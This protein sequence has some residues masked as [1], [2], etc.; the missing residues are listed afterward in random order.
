MRSRPFARAIAMYALV[1]AAMAFPIGG[2]RESAMRNI[3]EY[4]S[5]GKGRGTY[6]ASRNT[7][8]MVQRAAKKRRNKA[9]HK[10]ACRK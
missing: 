7:A 8:A 2:G 9:R 4:K 3:G 6:Q 5:R 10:A 1:Q